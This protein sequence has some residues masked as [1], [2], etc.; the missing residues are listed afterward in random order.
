MLRGFF[1]Y[2]I[3]ISGLLLLDVNPFSDPSP[4]QYIWLAGFLSLFGFVLSYEPRLFRKIIV[5]SYHQIENREGPS[6]VSDRA[7]INVHY[8]KETTHESATIHKA[9]DG[10]DTLKLPPSP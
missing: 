1:V 6:R 2:L 3:M 5:W 8:E 4:S 7:G 9:P 10:T